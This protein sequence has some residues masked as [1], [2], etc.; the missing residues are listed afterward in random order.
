MATI[1]AKLEA[2]TRYGSVYAL[3][4]NREAI[5]DVAIER[6]TE[7]WTPYVP[8]NDYEDCVFT[9]IHRGRKM[10]DVSWIVDELERELGISSQPSRYFFFSSR[11]RHTRFEGDWSSDVCSSD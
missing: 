1:E 6:V 3:L 9:A 11:R 5:L 10:E 7:A 2:R 4:S 8:K